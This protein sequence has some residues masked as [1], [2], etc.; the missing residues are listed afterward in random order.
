MPNEVSRLTSARY[1]TYSEL[2]TALA[3]TNEQAHNYALRRMWPRHMDSWGRQRVSVPESELQSRS[4]D[5]L[6]DSHVLNIL[7]QH[8]ARLEKIQEEVVAEIAELHA[9]M[10]SEGA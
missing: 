8:V 6:S 5:L 7:A 1:M 9:R 2:A 10:A 4:T 3:M